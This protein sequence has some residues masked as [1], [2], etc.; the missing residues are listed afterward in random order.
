MLFLI[1]YENVGNAG[2]RG[3]NYLNTQDHV[4]VFYS[5]AKKHMEQRAL[6]A[7]SGS[8]CTFEICKLCKTGKNA[9]DFYIATRLG[10][11][12]GEGYEGIAVIVSN[13]SGF[14]A[15][16]DYWEKRAAHKRKVVLSNCIEDGIVSGNENN[17]RT[18]ELRRLR[19][20]LAIGGYYSAYTE[21]MRI[22]TVLRKIFEGTQYE[23]KVEEIQNMLDG[24]EKNSK[25]IY[26]DS[27][28]LFGRKGGLEVYNKIKAC[29]ELL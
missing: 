29:N 26:L 14:Q 17:E 9:L 12:F 6:E 3:C 11:L 7:V 13:D 1:D 5:E 24:K 2:M 22:K 23:S 25:I 27:L 19:E 20:K 8:G 18:R 21:R 16:R 4:I 10:E 28:H 15:V